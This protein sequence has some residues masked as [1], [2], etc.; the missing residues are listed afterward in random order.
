MG[1]FGKGLLGMLAQEKRRRDFFE[2]ASRSQ[3]SVRMFECRYC[4]KKHGSVSRPAAN[5]YGKCPN[6]PYGTHY[7]DEV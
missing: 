7:W 4:G 5:R 2:A 3:G 1:L 6:S